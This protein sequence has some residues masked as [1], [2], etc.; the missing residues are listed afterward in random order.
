MVMA[1]TKAA[2]RSQM[3]KAAAPPTNAQSQ[4]GGTPGD[5][6]LD[7]RLLNCIRENAETIVSWGMSES[8]RFVE[9]QRR[10]CI[11]L[12]NQISTLTGLG[13]IQLAMGKSAGR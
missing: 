5:R 6:K 1:I 7:I 13:E 8:R 12:A 2:V 10:E 9:P 4:N 11:A 3:K